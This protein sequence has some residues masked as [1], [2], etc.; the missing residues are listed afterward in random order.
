MA[1]RNKCSTSLDCKAIENSTLLIGGSGSRTFEKEDSTLSRWGSGSHVSKN[2]DAFIFIL[3]GLT[4]VEEEGHTV[5]RNARNDP[6]NY[7]VTLAAISL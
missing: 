1:G 2:R 5:F 7:T 6:P 3:P 4:A